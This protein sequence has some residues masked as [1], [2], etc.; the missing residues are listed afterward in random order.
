M[1]EFLTQER[2][3]QIAELVEHPNLPPVR[4]SPC[5]AW[6]LDA[7]TGRPVSRWVLSDAQGAPSLRA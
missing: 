5:L 4:L 6:M 1:T 2:L 3:R 7:E